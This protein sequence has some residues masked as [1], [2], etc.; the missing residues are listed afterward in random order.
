MLLVFFGPRRKL[1]SPFS[2]V[3]PERL[4]LLLQVSPSVIQ[5]QI[6]H[7]HFDNCDNRLVVAT[8]HMPGGAR[9]S[10]SFHKNFRFLFS[11]SF[12]S[13]F[14]SHHQAVIDC[15]A[16]LLLASRHWLLM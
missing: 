6:D 3:R 4:A 2:F 9:P 14:I 8:R 15:S 11:S 7:F 16:T 1:A 12:S 13:L 5:P 10:N